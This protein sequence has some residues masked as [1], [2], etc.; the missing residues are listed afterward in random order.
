M[1]K[2]LWLARDGKNYTELYADKP[3]WCEKDGIWKTDEA[4]GPESKWDII[5]PY[6]VLYDSL[7]PISPGECKKIRI[8]VVD[9]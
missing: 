2:T 6:D 9:G 5:D 1:A 4:Y 3:R 8:E 7:P